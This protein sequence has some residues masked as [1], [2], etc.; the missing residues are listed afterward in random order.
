M[1]LIRTNKTA[2]K[3]TDWRERLDI[4]VEMMRTVSN[5]SDPQGMVREYGNRIQL[6][7]PD[8]TN[9]VAVSRRGLPTPRYKITRSSRWEKEIDPWRDG[10]TL[11]IYESGI[12][13][14]LLYGDEPRIIPDLHVEKSDPAYEYFSEQRSLM[15]TPLYDGGIG[16]N[17]VV[18]MRPEPDA[19]DPTS[20]ADWVLL[21]NLFGRAT[22][23]LVLSNQLEAAYKTIDHELK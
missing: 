17:M 21:S 6:L 3:E 4:V 7:M 12:L 22:H 13:G 8:I 11:P 10:H 18:L 15:A 23:N 14:E 20:F 9:M 19:F 1:E 5:Q 2:A 16:L